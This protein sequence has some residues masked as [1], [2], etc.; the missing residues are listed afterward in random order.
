MLLRLLSRLK[1]KRTRPFSGSKVREIFQK[2]Y[3]SFKSVLEANSELLK[4]ISDF[5][6]KLSE[7][8]I[9]PMAYIRT[10][11]AR[12]IFHAE[13]MVKSFEQLSGRPYP[14]FR[15][16]LNRM[17]DLFAAQRDKKPAPATTDYVIPYTSINKE[18]IAA[19]GGKSANLGEIKALGFPI[20]RGFAITTKA[21][22]ELIQAN[23][24][25]DQIRMQKMELNTNDPESIDRISRNIQDL[26]LKAIVPP[27]V[28]QAILDAYERFV[29]DRKQTHVALRS[30]AIGEDS[31]LTFAGQYLTVL[32]VPP[33]KIIPEY[34]K[35]LA[36]LFTPRA[37]FYRLY[38]NIP[39][40]EAVMSVA[41]LEMVD[42]KASGV[43]YTASP[44]DL[45]DNN[46]LINA[47]W[48]LGTSVVDG[49][50]TPD[51][52][53]LSKEPGHNLL[54]AN[55]ANK[56]GLVTIHPDG[57]VMEKTVE[58]NLQKHPCLRPEQMAQLAGYAVMIEKHYKCPQDIE[59]AVDKHDQVIIL[60]SRPLRIEDR[61]TEE[62]I[63]R[64]YPGHAVILADG[65]I[66]CPGVGFGPAF[67]VRSVQELKDFPEGAVLVTNQSSPLYVMVMKK[68]SAIVVE[69]GS[70]TGH[71]ASLARE[72][73]VPTLLNMKNAMSLIQKDEFIT[74]D[75]A[76]GRIYQGKVEEL[77][78]QQRPK[79][80]IIYTPVYQALK[81]I[82]EH[83]IPLNLTNPNSSKFTPENCKTIHDVMRFIHE[84]SYTE[85]FNISDYTT[86]YGN[87]S[88]KL[89][90]P[91]PLDLYVI[92][93]G[94]GLINLPGTKA[95][96]GKVSIDA[97]VSAPF[98]AILSGMLHKGLI[99]GEPRPV[100]F[101]GFISVMSEQ[102]LSPQA[103]S[104]NRFGEKSFAIISDKY[105][106]FS[107][108]VGYHYSILD[109][110]CGPVPNMNYINFSFMGGAADLLRRS[111][112]ARLIQQILQSLKFLVE[113]H[114]DRV[115][116]R[117]TKQPEEII[118]E[119]LDQVGRL[120]IYTR[121]MDML[122]HT[123]QS[124]TTLSESFLKEDYRFKPS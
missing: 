108:R 31:D 38:M 57:Y 82:S 19:V 3:T 101:K 10:Q 95:E 48:G 107:S 42:A 71:M 49:R 62:A 83:I 90:A 22:H 80:T 50:A 122:M 24:L 84:R 26:F 15:E 58:E 100:N 14:P 78:Q 2:K 32:N 116:A 93:L 46:I 112:R 28:E 120:L 16:M 103:N 51:V 65:D 76:N 64:E 69:S 75:A 91:L 60:Q 63:A 74:V 94:Q 5:E 45:Q 12:V 13:R 44:Y 98:K 118:Q 121:Q 55:I 111:R 6:Q 47:L 66:A 72:F 53:K 79:P 34:L 1:I 25:L 9:F 20:P 92:D 124:I 115:T 105:M 52:Y 61:G 87:I 117:F 17:N 59:W 29:D 67:P 11:T 114:G 85:M 96:R 7:N 21:F 35:V 70:V 36:S 27:P 54:S 119:K 106:N 4:I 89:N 37:I 43:L 18:M 30:S 104:A 123:E 113:V 56:S 68:A 77:I 41:C 88:F 99:H 73:H 8:S 81:L 39:F 40:G 102:M 109:A 86:D 23:D 110:Y 97:V 33:D